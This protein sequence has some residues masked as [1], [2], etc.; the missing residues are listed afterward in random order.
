[1]VKSAFLTA[2]LLIS[3]WIAFAQPASAALSKDAGHPDSCD[4]RTFSVVLL[5]DGTR[6]SLEWDGWRIEPDFGE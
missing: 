2:G 4:T 1:M 6:E 3:P 5:P